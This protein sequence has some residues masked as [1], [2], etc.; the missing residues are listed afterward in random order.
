MDQSMTPALKQIEEHEKLRKQC[1]DDLK[2]I[3]L[4][5]GALGVWKDN[6]AKLQDAMLQTI[7]KAGVLEQENNLLKREQDVLI[8]PPNDQQFLIA[9]AIEKLRAAWGTTLEQVWE[10]QQIAMAT[11]RT[12]IEGEEK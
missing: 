6:H 3:S 10:M 2:A 5:D 4:R 8:L 1:F 7:A 9:A 11:R 12:S